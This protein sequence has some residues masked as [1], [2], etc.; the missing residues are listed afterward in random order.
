MY[1]GMRS[2]QSQVYTIIEGGPTSVE[3]L[4]EK[5]SRE[6]EA[7]QRAQRG[8]RE[9]TTLRKHHQDTVRYQG[10]K[11]KGKELGTRSTESRENPK[12]KV[13]PLS[14]RINGDRKVFIKRGP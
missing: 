9:A 4:K 10:V 14:I 12:R 2:R 13:E 6:D 3:R 1:T 5:V 7:A 8:S 11:T